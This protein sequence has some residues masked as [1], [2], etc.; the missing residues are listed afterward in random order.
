MTGR[1]MSKNETKIAC[2]N[3]ARVEKSLDSYAYAC[4]WA[5]L[6]AECARRREGRIVWVEQVLT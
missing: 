5:E 2:S 6:L 3:A 1:G 4:A